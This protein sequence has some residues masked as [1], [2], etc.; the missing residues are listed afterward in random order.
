MLVEGVARDLVHAFKY[1]GA[2]YLIKDFR[3]LF[4]MN[5]EIKAYIREAILVPVPL[6]PRKLRERG[7][8][9]SLELC[10]QLAAIESSAS[11]ADVLKRVVDTPSQTLFSREKRLKNLRKAFVLEEDANVS[12]EDRYIIVDDVFTTGSTLN[13]CA[14]PLKKAGIQRIDILTLGHG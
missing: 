2:R 3:R 11:I 6:H 4:E 1:E 13:S 10:K 14:R 7:F 9:Q 8:N 12:P 5:A